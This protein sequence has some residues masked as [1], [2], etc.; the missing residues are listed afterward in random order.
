MLAD[1]N[2]KGYFTSD[3][4]GG[5]IVVSSL[6]DEGHMLEVVMHELVHAIDYYFGLRLEHPQVHGLGTGLAQAL[7]P[8]MRSK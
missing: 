1:D 2:G 5:R 3:K 7:M 6:L 4:E 8:H